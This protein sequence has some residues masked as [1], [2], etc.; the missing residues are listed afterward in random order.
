MKKFDDTI[1]GKTGHGG[2]ER[3]R[4]KF[5]N[6]KTLVNKLYV[7]VAPFRC[8]AV[9]NLPEDLRVMGEVVRFEYSCLAEYVERFEALPKFNDKKQSPKYS[10]TLGR[11]AERK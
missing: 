8:D 5:Y 6:Y 2:A 9:S 11:I 3:V 1:V 10:L 4:Y 7:A